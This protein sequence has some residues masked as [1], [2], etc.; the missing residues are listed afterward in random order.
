MVH[1]KKVITIL[2]WKLKRCHG[3]R[4]HVTQVDGLQ[5]GQEHPQGKHR[6]VIVDNEPQ[7]QKTQDSIQLLEWLRLLFRKPKVHNELTK[8]GSFYINRHKFMKQQLIGNL[9]RPALYDN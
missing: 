6:M 4:I 8:F 7:L 5:G 9:S 3:T 2:C 1:F